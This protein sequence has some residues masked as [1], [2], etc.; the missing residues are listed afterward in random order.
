MFAGGDC[1]VRADGDAT[2]PLIDRGSNRSLNER[3]RFVSGGLPTSKSLTAE[4]HRRSVEAPVCQAGRRQSEDAVDVSLGRID[5]LFD[6]SRSEVV[7]SPLQLLQANRAAASGT[8]PPAQAQSR[9]FD[10]FLLYGHGDRRELVEIAHASERSASSSPVIV[11]SS[12]F[13]PLS[14]SPIG[15]MLEEVLG[16]EATERHQGHG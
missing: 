9:D 3:V 6:D 14:E 13:D 16:S 12:S 4:Q 2:L 15:V 8:P 11:A 5:M 10:L 1:C 7:R